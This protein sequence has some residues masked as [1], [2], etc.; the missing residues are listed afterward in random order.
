MK[1]FKTRDYQSMDNP[2]PKEPYRPE[3][4]T[5]DHGAQ[6]LGGMFAILAPNTQVPYHYHNNRESV[7]SVISGEG[8][9]IMDGEEHTIKAG[10][11]IF[12]PAGVKHATLNNTDQELRYI[13]FYTHPPLGS[14]FVEV[15]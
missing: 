10:D 7:I 6:N 13:E 1:V 11:I 8:I 2:T 3:I 5:S 12:I 9:E 4:L 15:K 14:D